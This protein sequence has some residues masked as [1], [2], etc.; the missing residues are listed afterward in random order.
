MTRSEA[1]SLIAG[2]LGERTGLETWIGTEMDACQQFDLER[3]ETLPWFLLTKAPIA[4]A[5]DDP[6]Y[7]VTG[8]L[9]ED[10]EG[11]LWCPD[12]DGRL[13][14]MKKDDY[15]ILKADDALQ[16]TGRPSHYAL[17]G[18]LFYLFPVPDAIYN[19]EL[20]FYKA[21]TIP[22]DAETNNWLTYA[23][24][25]LV[26]STGYRMARHLRD[27]DAVALFKEDL[28]QARARLLKEDTA[29]RH[30]GMAEYMGG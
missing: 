19:L 24:D 27:K 6:D 21:D 10:D 29:R 16:D 7:T 28:L 3:G 14:L 20:H 15:S 5:A 2:R 30:A 22:G 26:A 17:K 11:G 4:T 8:F 23:A 1:I 25:V 9:R 12:E 13:R 18:L